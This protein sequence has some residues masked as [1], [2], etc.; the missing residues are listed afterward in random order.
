MASNNPKKRPKKNMKPESELPQDDVD[1][2]IPGELISS[3]L[4]AELEDYITKKKL[5]HTS[6]E[7]LSNVLKEHLSFSQYTTTKICPFS[8]NYG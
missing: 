7:I 8:H 2:E 1:I 6:A 5:D 3:I 4:D